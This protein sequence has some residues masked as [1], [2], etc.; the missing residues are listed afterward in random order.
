M[1]KPLSIALLGC[2]TVGSGVVR[3]LLEQ[4]ER[5]AKRAGR[6]LRLR[7]ILVR[8]PSKM[9]P[10]DVPPELLTTNFDDIL[11]DPEIDAVAE[12]IGGEQFAKE[13]VLKLLTKG[14][15]IVTANKALLALHGNEVFETA[16]RYERTVAFEAS[17]AGG[18]PIIA[19]L[20]QSLAANQV[21]ALQSILNGTCNYILTS[22][23]ES[24]KSYEDSLREAQEKG[25]A[26]ADPTLDVDGTDA[27]HKLSILAQI[28]FNVAIPFHSI[29][30]RGIENV[31]ALDIGY[32]DELGYRIKLLAEGWLN[33]D[34]LA[35]HV[36]PVLL[37]KN[38]PLAL[39]RG[40]NNAIQVVGDAVGETIYYGPGAGQMPTAS[41]VV[42]DCI[43]LAVGRA[44]RTFQAHRLW[45]EDVP[46]PSYQMS[47]TVRCRYY[48]RMKVQDRPGVLGEVAN[49]LALHDIS[50]ASVI[51]HEVPDDME[52]EWVQMVIMTHTSPTSRFKA[53]VSEINELSCLSGSCVYYPVAES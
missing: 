45:S 38:A 13:A 15:D 27:A 44:Q 4:S 53:A 34:Q 31:T 5:L 3:L 39:V 16:R 7:R 1:N 24:G 11:N 18:V 47:G 28:A 33:E 50:I 23:T 25:F 6:P 43:D 32:A 19:A 9:R 40:A 41:A 29:A 35:M 51:Q 30:R 21:L 52:G 49:T 46:H 10:C 2:G 14:K 20:T 36:S 37:R 8:N 26:E 42:A 12:L 48:L 22:M 17:V